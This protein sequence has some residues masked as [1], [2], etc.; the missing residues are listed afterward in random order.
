MEWMIPAN[1]EIYD[2]AKDLI[3]VCPNCHSMI[4]RLTGGEKMSTEEIK[5]KIQLKER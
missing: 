4:H 5:A 2:Y 1:A 3:P